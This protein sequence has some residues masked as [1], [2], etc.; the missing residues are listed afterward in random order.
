VPV[1]NGAKTLRRL[2]ESIASQTF[3]DFQVNMV[4]NCSEDETGSICREFADRDNRFKY[5][6]NRRNMGVNYSFKYCFFLAAESDF[7]VY[8]GHDDYWASEYLEKCVSALDANPKAVLAYTWVKLLD[9]DGNIYND[10]KDDF[11]LSIPDPY[12]RYLIM[13]GQ[14]KMLNCHYGVIRVQTWA[15]NIH[16]MD[17]SSAA[18]DN[19]I[20][21]SMAI[22]GPFIQIN[23]PLFYRTPPGVRYFD[24]STA[25]RYDRLLKMSAGTPKGDGNRPMLHGP[26][27]SMTNFILQNCFIIM[28][29]ADIFDY[30]QQ[31]ALTAETIRMLSLRYTKTLND[32]ITILMDSII[33]GNIYNNN[34]ASVADDNLEAVPHHGRYK[35]IDHIDLHRKLNMLN[36]YR[37]LL[38]DNTPGLH[39]VRALILLLMGRRTE[40]VEA[41]TT[42]LHFNPT[43][44]NATELMLKFKQ[45]LP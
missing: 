23:E 16:L 31:N 34:K 19:V 33:S 39:Y 37:T 9:L 8:V 20:M 5:Y 28:S 27:L 17:R 35:F 42:E 15:D 41:L 11:D 3:T 44:R 13:I 36:L 24:E 30:D 1:Y 2:L 32:E 22:E 45:L 40:A 29:H 4:D 12:R 10:Y 7:M 38:G 21:T 18:G 43:H 26:D 25:D 6:R 14:L